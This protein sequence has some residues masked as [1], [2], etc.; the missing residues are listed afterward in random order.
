MDGQE[1]SG[2]KGGHEFG[3]LGLENRVYGGV[4]R[5]REGGDRERERAFGKRSIL[6]TLSSMFHCYRLYCRMSG[7]AASRA[8]TSCYT[9]LV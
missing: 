9:K 4:E 6:P 7:L 8:I 3:V 1:A 2:D 5:A